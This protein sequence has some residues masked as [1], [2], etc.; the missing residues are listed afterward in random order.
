MV[1]VVLAGSWA[2]L[3]FRS[4]RKGL[5]PDIVATLGLLGLLIVIHIKTIVFAPLP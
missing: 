3:R 1:I 4:P 2:A 5:A